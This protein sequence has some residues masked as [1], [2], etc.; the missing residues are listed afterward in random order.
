MGSLNAQFLL[1]NLKSFK[2]F[3]V[4]LFQCNQISQLVCIGF[5]I[6]FQLLLLS[7]LVVTTASLI[8]VDFLIILLCCVVAV[9]M[10]SL[11]G[12]DLRLELTKTCSYLL[13]LESTIAASSLT[14]QQLLLNDCAQLMLF[15]QE[16]ALV[17]LC[18]ELISGE[19]L[20]LIDIC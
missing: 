12:R 5:L 6:C 16:I 4:L 19:W 1:L 7:F 15:I 9:S 14:G 10:K 17:A 2:C 8:S 18:E 3:Q 13:G 11:D 20:V